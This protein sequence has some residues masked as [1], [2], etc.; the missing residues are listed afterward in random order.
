M[1]AIVAPWGAKAKA[2]MGASPTPGIHAA[3]FACLVG[4]E[5][6]SQGK[7]MSPS[8]SRAIRPRLHIGNREIPLRDRLGTSSAAAGI[9]PES[10]ASRRAGDPLG[11]PGRPVG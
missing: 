5:I 4:P 1:V 2:R 7:T 6:G 8:R 11:D 9:G 10:V 3:G